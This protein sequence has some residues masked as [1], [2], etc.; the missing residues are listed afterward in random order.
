[1]LAST[2]ERTKGK[3]SR[4]EEKVFGRRGGVAEEEKQTVTTE[5]L[6]R[7]SENLKA[8]KKKEKRRSRSKRYTTERSTYTRQDRRIEDPRCSAKTREKKSS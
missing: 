8:E 4:R 1:M 2:K 7:P 5:V 6:A 3:G